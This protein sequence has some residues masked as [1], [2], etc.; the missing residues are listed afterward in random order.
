MLTSIDIDKRLKR[1]LQEK[2]PS[3][4]IRTK[5]KP[6]SNNQDGLKYISGASCIDKLNNLT[7]YMWDWKI[8]NYF[9]QESVPYKN[10]RNNNTLTSQNPVAHVIGTL[11]VW[12]KDQNGN[13][14]PIKKSATG[15]QSVIGSQQEQEN[16]FKAASTDALKKAASLLGIGT[17]LYR[18]KEEQ[19]YFME[20]QQ[21]SPYDD[22]KIYEAHKNDFIFL[23]KLKEVYNIDDEQ[24]NDAINEWS[25][26]Q[27][28]TLTF[29]PPEKLTEFVKA[30]KDLLE[31]S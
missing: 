6:G 23:D 18:S 27:Y 11:T 28:K 20:M 30:K 31:V 16:I 8:E 1:K 14:I 10:K 13:L 2:F 19:D 21:P 22:D 4:V 3:S 26:G 15:C 7:N 12:L 9:I 24:I 25:N 5:P 29:L 17:E